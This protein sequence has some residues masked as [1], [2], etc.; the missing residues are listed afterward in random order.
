MGR[1]VFFTTGLEY[2]FTVAVQPSQDIWEF[3]GST[4]KDAHEDPEHRWSV[5]DLPQI[6]EQLED[7]EKNNGWPEMNWSQFPL[8]LEGTHAVR[9]EIDSY[10]GYEPNECLYRLGCLIYHQL[11]YD[12]H[13]KATY[14][15]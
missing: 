7:M 14:E 12:P 6:K 3:G 1:Y 11:Q 13:L 15:L 10:L 9:R 8:S 4:F 5:K 2:K